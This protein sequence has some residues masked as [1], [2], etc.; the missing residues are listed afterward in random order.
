MVEFLRHFFGFCGEGHPSLLYL[1]TITPL[2]ALRV[3]FKNLVR[4]ILTLKNYLKHL[5]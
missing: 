1:L 3:Y 4:I 5:R 2:I